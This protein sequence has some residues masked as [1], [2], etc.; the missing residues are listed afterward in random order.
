MLKW[1]QPARSG[2]SNTSFHPIERHQ[3]HAYGGRLHLTGGRL[4]HVGGFRC[5]D[6]ALR[7]QSQ[8]GKRNAARPAHGRAG[9][10]HLRLPDA[11]FHH[12]GHRI[13][14]PSGR[15]PHPGDSFGTVCGFSG[16]GGHP[17]GAGA[18]LCGR[19]AAGP[20]LQHL[21][22][23]LLLLPGGL[24]LH[25]QAPG[26]QTPRHGPYYAVQRHRRRHRASDGSLRRRPGNNGLRHL[27]T[28]LRPIRGT[29]AAHSSGHR[30]RR[31]ACYGRRRHL[32]Q[33]GTAIPAAPGRFGNRNRQKSILDRVGHLCGSGPALRGRPL[34]VRLHLS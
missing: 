14:R 12:S 3:H 18:F 33:Q 24:P 5:N 21:Q 29:D 15:R 30:R 2:A 9:G 34:L 26:R 25:L 17:G 19:R 27:S 23:G 16:H 32:H 4:Y 7:A 10:L 11:E 20:G 8:A 13:Q 31:R 22:H 28:A 1:R 6:N